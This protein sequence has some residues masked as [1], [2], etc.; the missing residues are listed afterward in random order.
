MKLLQAAFL[1]SFAIRAVW[2]ADPVPP[3]ALTGMVD[4]YLT[5]IAS[6][7]WTE[8]SSRLAALR[9][10]ADVTERQ[11][12]IRAKLLDTLGGFPQSKTPLAPKITGSF[13]RDGYRVDRLIYESL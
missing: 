8:R 13:T 7:F 6:K 3:G 2:A 9:T 1:L 5:A 11:K 10:P 12:Y 4:R